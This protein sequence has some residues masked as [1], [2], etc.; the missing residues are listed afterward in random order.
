MREILR[1][2]DLCPDTDFFEA[3]GDSLLAITLMLRLDREC[4]RKHPAR[5]LDGA[6]TARRLAT[7]LDSP[8]GLRATC[9]TSV[10]Q[11]KAGTTYK[12]LFCMPGGLRAVAVKLR[13][14]RPILGIELGDLLTGSALDSIE[15]LAKAIVERMRE[16]DPV[17][18]YAI[19]GYSFGG[20]LAVEVA[21]Q[22]TASDQTVELVAII[23][24]FVP[25][26][27]PKGLPKIA[28]HLQ[29]IASQTLQDSYK[30]I[31]SRIQR[32][33]QDSSKY[34]SSLPKSDT[35]RRMVE[36]YK[37]CMRAFNAHHPK[38]FSG[39]IVLVQA[40]EP[41]NPNQ[42]ADPSGTNGWGS[43][44]KGGVDV[45]PMD[46]RHQDLVKEPHITE[47]ARHIDDLLNAL[48]S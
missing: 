5:V 15:N 44:C 34:I 45:I 29:I 26:M 24:S 17:G 48:D 2:G 12:P 11:F 40:K 18:P 23:D 22:L 14:R 9:P 13:T 20:N 35:E 1:D 42:I 6:L 43:L 3:G 28:M 7:I 46:C 32:R 4:G 25:S 31:A 47:L 30:Y 16:A 21:R 27:L 33:L 10:V 19:I 37:H 41:R 36:I 8:S 39:R 38:P